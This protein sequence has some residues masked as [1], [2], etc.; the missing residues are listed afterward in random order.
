MNEDFLR[1][2]LTGKMITTLDPGFRQT[3]DG[4]IWNGRKPP[5]RAR[6]IVHAANAA[7][8]QLCVRFAA[9]NGLTISP[10]GGGHH[11][12]GISTQADLVVDLAAL[13]HLRIDVAAKVC[14]SGPAVTNER[15]NAAL[16]RHGLA[17][18]VGHC[19]SVPM[20][21]YLLGGGVGWNS[22][23]WGIACFL[24]ESADV[25]LPDGSLVTVSKSEHPE[26]FWAMRGAG[27][28]FFGIV[29]SYRLNLMP[30]A[31]SILS[32]VRVYP[33]AD[34]REVA[35]WLD[36][37]SKRAPANAEMTLKV[38]TQ[39]GP[40]GPVLAVTAILTAFGTSEAEAKAILTEIGQDAPEGYFAMMPEM[41][42][43]IGA[44]YEMTAAGTPKGKRY[45]L[46]SLWS[47]ADLASVVSHIVEGMERTPS[48]STF[49][50]IS[51]SSRHAVV[52]ADA[53]F[54]R[55][56]RI[57]GAVYT[58]WEDTAADEVNMAWLRDLMDRAAPLKSG[59]Y[60]G[61]GDIDLAKRREEVHSPAVAARLAALRSRY[62]VKGIFLR[63]RG[64]DW[65]KVA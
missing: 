58:I 62:D 51:P 35:T 16:D 28:G 43:P 10:R 22:G 3:A 55:I 17:F 60:V 40:I 49:A 38:E 41:P 33:A 23:Q 63:H 9:A 27:P 44:L 31:R 2:L 45:G 53:A 42:T 65:E 24:I 19:G 6:Y 15:L 59:I 25:V 7:D 20:S 56:G 57:F 14:D 13:D 11:F 36:A 26:L 8:V 54:S 46:D 47:D 48:A 64:P 30:A 12:T 4:L 1:K 39:M 21:G 37:A 29:T 18:P 61:Y 52:P 34:A 5:V 50:V 32:T